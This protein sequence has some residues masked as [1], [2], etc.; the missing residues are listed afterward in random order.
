MQDSE[1]GVIL[2]NYENDDICERFTSFTSI[3]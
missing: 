3:V 1:M 2:Y